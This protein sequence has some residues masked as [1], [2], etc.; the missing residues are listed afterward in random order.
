MNFKSKHGH[1]VLRFKAL[2]FFLF[3]SNM[4]CVQSSHLSIHHSKSWERCFLQ[5]PNELPINAAKFLT[6]ATS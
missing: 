5:Q 2:I 4:D 3:T 1:S 6:Q